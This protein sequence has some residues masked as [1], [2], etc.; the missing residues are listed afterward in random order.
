MK[1]EN[2]AIPVVY[3]FQ[4]LKEG[5]VFLNYDDINKGFVFM[6][7]PESCINSLEDSGN[8]FNAVCLNDGDIYFFN[9]H[10]EVARVDASLTIKPKI[11]K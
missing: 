5:E 11:S 2:Y 6:K 3:E 4:N 1:I 10:D 9:T 8:E 7:V